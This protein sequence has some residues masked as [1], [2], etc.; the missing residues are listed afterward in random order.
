MTYHL[1]LKVV[2]I[3]LGLLG[4]TT[5]LIAMMRP[6]AVR[7]ALVGLPRNFRAGAITMAIGIIWM[8]ILVFNVDLTEM[9]QYRTWLL[10][11]FSA[12]GVMTI[13]YL[14]DFLFARALGV[15]L[16]LAAELLFSA[17][18]PALHPARH[19]ITIIGYIWAI[20]GMCFVVAPYLVRDLIDITHRDDATA[21][22][23]GAIRSAL[24]LVILALGIT[25]F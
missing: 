15:I 7:R 6:G 20:A 13:I 25:C 12:L 5:G 18:F 3:I 1:S 24:G 11:F 17:T 23:T 4:I 14:P 8:D 22:R 21:R 16:L 10:I 9:A 2:A 19:V